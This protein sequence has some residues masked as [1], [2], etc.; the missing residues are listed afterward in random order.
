[1]D[2]AAGNVRC[3]SRIYQLG[4]V[5]SEWLARLEAMGHALQEFDGDHP[6]RPVPMELPAE[7]AS[8]SM[9][10][11]KKFA[12]H[13][14]FC[15]T[16]VFVRDGNGEIAHDGGKALTVRCEEGARIESAWMRAQTPKAT[17]K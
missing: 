1:M 8:N 2:L 13:M 5:D 10:P 9:T 12:A 7:R 14:E 17:K 6:F 16:C 3:E 4:A 11:R 15:E